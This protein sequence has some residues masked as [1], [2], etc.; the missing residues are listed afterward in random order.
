[1]K[2]AMEG[3]PVAV[4]ESDYLTWIFG[5]ASA[6]FAVLTGAISKLWAKTVVDAKDRETALMKDNADLKADFERRIAANE[7]KIEKQD[8]EV[9]DCHKQREEM[10]VEMAQVKTRLEIIESQMNCVPKAK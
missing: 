3:E 8:A 1:M 5:G 6:V 9:A 10:H 4:D 7:A 2:T